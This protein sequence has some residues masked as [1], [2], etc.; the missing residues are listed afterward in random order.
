MEE[1]PAAS[2]KREVNA[3]LREQAR[4][5]ECARCRPSRYATRIDGQKKFQAWSNPNPTKF[6]S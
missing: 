5:P 6:L 1:L 4:A 3:I 2:Y